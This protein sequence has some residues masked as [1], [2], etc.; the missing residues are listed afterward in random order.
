MEDL[1]DIQIFVSNYNRP[2]YANRSF[3]S[4]AKNAAGI[5]TLVLD[6]HSKLSNYK[7]LEGMMGKNMRLVRNT[8]NLGID[9]VMVS[10][11]DYLL[12]DKN[13]VYISDNDVLYSSRFRDALRVACAVAYDYDGI[14]SLHNSNQHHFKNVGYE[15]AKYEISYGF[16]FKSSLGGV[17]MCMT[18]ELFK[19]LVSHLMSKYRKGHANW[20]WLAVDWCAD[21]VPLICSYASFVSHIGTEGLHCDLT[22][23]DTSLNFIK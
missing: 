12:K 15:V 11:K 19:R 2:E 10:Y 17:S 20:D 3:A 22:H 16:G 21:R 9:Q 23:T 1:K 6:D 5:D 18:A 13:F 7:M 4:F 14:V 8:E